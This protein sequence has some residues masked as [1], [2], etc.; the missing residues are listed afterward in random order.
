M[1]GG[2]R[3]LRLDFDTV[4][5]VIGSRDGGASEHLKAFHMLQEW[6]RRAALD[7][8]FTR[9]RRGGVKQLCTKTLLHRTSLTDFNGGKKQELGTCMVAD[10]TM[11]TLLQVG[12]ASVGG[13]HLSSHSQSVDT[14]RAAVTH[15]LP[16]AHSSIKLQEA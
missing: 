7:F 10:V 2:G 12:W 9:S 1:G 15:H 5:G 13:R 14:Q 6:K 8:T 4:T 11:V 16:T 3:S